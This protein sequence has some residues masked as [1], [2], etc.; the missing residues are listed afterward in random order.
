MLSGNGMEEVMIR[1]KM[2]LLIND[3]NKAYN[4]LRNENKGV[5]AMQRNIQSL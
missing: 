2:R 4:D 1:E 5:G 3:P